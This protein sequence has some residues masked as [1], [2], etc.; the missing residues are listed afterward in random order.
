MNSQLDSTKEYVS[1]FFAHIVNALPKLLGA[2]VILLIGYIVAKALA[3][4]VRKALQVA[5]LD[6]RAHSGKTGSYVQK[7]LPHPTEFVAKAVYWAVF[8]FGVS[9]AVSALGIPVLADFVT[10]IY[11]YLPN[12]IAA[13]LIFMVAGAISAAVATLATSTM[14]HT[15]TG[16]LIASAGPVVVMGLAVFMILTQLKIAPAIVTLTYAGIVATAT[17]AFG[18]GG[19]DVAAQIL[20][21]IYD[22]G[23]QK[24]DQAAADLRSGVAKGKQKTDDLRGR[25]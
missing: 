18:L 25:L 9:I 2:L 22:K 14:G 17:L 23:A 10:A 12:V 4:V 3:G 16:K 19:K 1:V 13:V 7:A 5:G 8:L 11:G 24:K 15:P 6:K 20:Q 21:G